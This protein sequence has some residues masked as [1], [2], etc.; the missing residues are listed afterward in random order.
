MA[1]V[2]PVAD[3]VDAD[4]GGDT[5]ADA[6]D[7]ADVALGPEG[8]RSGEAEG[9]NA[10][11]PEVSDGTG[12]A[13]EPKESRLRLPRVCDGSRRPSAPRPNA[14]P[15]LADGNAWC[16]WCASEVNEN[17]RPAGRSVVGPPRCEW[18]P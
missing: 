15:G 3:S 4:A 17:R 12:L 10:G 7:A 6:A 8:D 2:I 9:T 1:V 16:A 13:M 5:T 14:T 18:F 11:E